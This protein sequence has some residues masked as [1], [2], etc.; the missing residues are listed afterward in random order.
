L[1]FRWRSA[2]PAREDI[3]LSS[4]VERYATPLT[5]GLFAVSGVSG[6]A[7][8][9]HWSQGTFH[10]MHEWLSMALLLPFGLHL[11]KNWRMLMGYLRRGI[12]PLALGASLALAVLFALPG[13]QQGREPGRGGAAAFQVMHLLTQTPLEQLAP[14]FKTD[15]DTLEQRLRQQGYPVLSAEDTLEKLAGG[16]DGAASQLLLTLLPARPPVAPGARAHD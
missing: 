8:F 7:L 6:V 13:A 10:E 16:S 2:A 14:V 9:F 12:L 3:A 5:T 1:G 4:F 11:W 15:T